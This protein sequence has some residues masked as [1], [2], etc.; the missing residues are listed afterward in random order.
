MAVLKTNF[1]RRIPFRASELALPRNSMPQNEDFLPRN[2]RN[3][4]ES[5][6]QNYFGT[7]FRYK[8]QCHMQIKSLRREDYM[9][10][11]EMPGMPLFDQ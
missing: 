9:D 11:Q 8:P 4:S 3:R 6:P 7:E 1:F 5:I 10:N 2:N